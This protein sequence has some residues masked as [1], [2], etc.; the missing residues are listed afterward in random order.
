M[1]TLSPVAV[2]PDLLHLHHVRIAGTSTGQR[3]RLPAPGPR[4]RPELDRTQEQAMTGPSLAALAVTDTLAAALADPQTVGQPSPPGSGGPGRSRC[5]AGAAGIALL[6][7]ERARSGHGDAGTAHAWLEVAASGRS[8]AAPNATC[9]T[10][11]PRWP[12][13]RTP[14]RHV[15]RLPARVRQPRRRHDDHPQPPGRRPRT[16]RPRRAARD[17]RVRPG[18][19]ADRPGR[20]TTSTATPTTRSPATCCPT[21]CA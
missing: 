1:S 8:T 10:A 4:R 19:R 2:L 6:H 20:L 7:I 12:S 15:G 5:W 16:H 17:E 21:W 11:P 13:S 3:A 14:P 18:P 9:S